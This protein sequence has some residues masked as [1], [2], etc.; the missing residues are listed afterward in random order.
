[1]KRRQS[2]PATKADIQALRTEFR[3]EIGASE[4]RVGVQFEDLRHDVLGALA[5]IQS[6]LKDKT[7]DHDR[8]I[9][10]LER[11]AGFSA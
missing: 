4:R 10:R 2:P 6:L 1:M 11:F 5:D 3:K 9:R 7:A 8:R